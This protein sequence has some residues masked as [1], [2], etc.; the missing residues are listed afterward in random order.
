MQARRKKE[1]KE[2]QR[3]REREREREMKKGMCVY[4]Q[5]Q[6]LIHGGRQIIV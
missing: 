5:V 1:R 6:L 3:E 4:L 2:L